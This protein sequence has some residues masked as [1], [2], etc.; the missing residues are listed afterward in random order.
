MKDPLRYDCED[1]EEPCDDDSDYCEE[2]PY[3][4]MRI[5][6][7]V[8]RDHDDFP[9]PSW[10]VENIWPTASR[11]FAI[12]ADI[13]ILGSPLSPLSEEEMEGLR[14]LKDEQLKRQ[15]HEQ[16]QQH[17]KTETEYRRNVPGR[18]RGK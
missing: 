5:A 17:R 8:A 18:W 11:L 9:D 10:V 7:S 2:C 15:M 6:A 3:D 12:Q 16:E 13:E 4:P 1:C 14:I